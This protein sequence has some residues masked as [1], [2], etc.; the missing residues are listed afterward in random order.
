MGAGVG[1]I[2]TVPGG[3]AAM[4]G[5]SM[6]CPAVTGVTARLLGKAPAVLAMP[7]NSDRTDAIR[8][9]LLDHAQTLGFDLKFEGKGLPK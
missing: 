9:L 2:S 8:K 5:T 7:R 6:A 4:S 3:H 1:V